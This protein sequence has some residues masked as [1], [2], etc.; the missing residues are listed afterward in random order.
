MPFV[1]VSH[2]SW[3]LM[4]NKKGQIN[5]K[6][7]T[8]NP[9]R[10]MRKTC[11]YLLCC[12]SK[13]F[14]D[15]GTTPTCSGLCAYIYMDG[16]FNFYFNYFN[17]FFYSHMAWFCSTDLVQELLFEIKMFVSIFS[18]IVSLWYNLLQLNDKTDATMKIK[19]DGYLSLAIKAANN[20]ENWSCFWSWNVA[21]ERNSNRAK[22]F[23]VCEADNWGSCITA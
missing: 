15:V 12:I 13:V 23:P 3:T 14:T 8:K 18:L 1:D 16:F 4:W 17:F 5:C 10:Q 22:E 20:L 2:L 9:T 11:L 7:Q 6:R 19:S 21:N